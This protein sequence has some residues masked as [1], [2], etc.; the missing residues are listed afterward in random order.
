MAE[1][2]VTDSAMS[3]LRLITRHPKVLPYWIGFNLLAATFALA[4]LFLLFG[5]FL[6]QVME[7]VINSGEPTPAMVFS[8]IPRIGLM[9]LIF[10]PFGLFVSAVRQ[11][12]ATRAILWP[13]D[14]RYGYLRVG[15]DEFRLMLVLF[16][17]GIIKGAIQLAI[18]LVLGIFFAIAL[19]LSGGFSAES[20]AGDRPILRLIVQLIMVYFFLRF[21]LAV[22]QTMDSRSVNIFGTWTLTKGH[23]G[24]MFLSYLIVGLIGFGFGLLTAALIVGFVIAAGG[25]ALM[26]IIPQF[27]T[28]RAGAIRALFDLIL[29][30]SIAF[31][32]IG[33]I[34]QPIFTA[35]VYCPAAYIYGKL[36][37]RTEDVF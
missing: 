6:R 23:V 30:I 20:M 8:L 3:G 28:D 31:A 35:L 25:G 27:D 10:L 17:V 11:G 21:A 36:T 2:E 26:T 24:R 16:V 37:G 34:M 7:L 33:S 29:P 32:I 1:F 5:D 14:D 9:L 12:A 4:L 19:G 22:P 15:G 13:D 18:G